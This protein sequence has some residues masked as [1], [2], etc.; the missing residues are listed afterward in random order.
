[1]NRTLV[2]IV[3]LIG[4]WLFLAPFLGPV[5]GLPFIP[6][7]NQMNMGMQMSGMAS[8]PAVTIN[9]AMVFF[10]LVPGVILMITSIYFLFQRRPQPAIA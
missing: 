2:A 7:M 9:R 3:G 10:N 1:V 5:I 6:H 8:T 4:L